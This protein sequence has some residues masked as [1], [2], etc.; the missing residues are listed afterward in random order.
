VAGLLDFYKVP[1]ERLVVVHDELDLPPGS[2]RVKFGGGDNGH[3]GLRSIRTAIATGDYFR[4]RV[5]I[6]RPGG[7][8]SASNHVLAPLGRRGVA[9]L[10][11]CVE[12]AA[13]AVDRLLR[14][15]LEE[16]QS[17]FNS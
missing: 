1:P 8:E 17:L 3:N 12:R 11:P 4:V 16:T 13:D 7:Q 5:G 15:G 14:R 2:L 10:S 9:A 6:G